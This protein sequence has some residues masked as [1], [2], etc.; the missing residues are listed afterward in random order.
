ML[1]L[2]FGILFTFFGL[3][4]YGQFYNGFEQDFG[5]NRIQNKDFDWNYLPFERYQVYY[6]LESTNIAEYA[7]Q[8]MQVVLTSIEKGLEYHLEEKIHV[9]VYKDIDDYRQ[10]NIGLSKDYQYGLSGVTKIAGSKIFIYNTGKKQDITAQ[11]KEGVARI[12]LNKMMFGSNWRD[13]IKNAGAMSLPEW[14]LEGL[15]SYIKNSHNPDFDVYLRDF[16]SSGKLKNFFHLNEENAITGGY[17]LWDYIAKTYGKKVIPNIIYMSRISRNIESGFLYVLGMPLKKVV[18]ECISFHLSSMNYQQQ[19][20]Q[21]FANN[22]IILGDNPNTYITDIKLSPYGNQIAYVEK[23][24]GLFRIQLLDIEENKSKTVFKGGYKNDWVK[25][26]DAPILTWVPSGDMIMFTLN[27][28][29][30]LQLY[31]YVIETKELAYKPLPKIDRVLSMSFSNDGKN[32]VMS[33]ISDGQTDLFEYSPR[34]NN[35]TQLTNDYYDELNPVYNQKN[36]ILFSSNR[37]SDTLSKVNHRPSRFYDLFSLTKGSNV[38]K[39]LTRTDDLDEMM[40]FQLDSIHYSY[41]A[42][43]DKIYNRYILRFDS[44][45]SHVDTAIHYKKVIH[46]LKTTDYP[47]SII[48]SQFNSKTGKLMEMFYLNQ[49]YYVRILP[50]S[51]S[52]VTLAESSDDTDEE[53]KKRMLNMVRSQ[54]ENIAYTIIPKRLPDSQS[55]DYIDTDNYVFTG[56][57]KM[58]K[59][60]PIELEVQT[61]VPKSQEPKKPEVLT[62]E[63]AKPKTELFKPISMPTP[64][65]YF[66]SISSSTFSSNIDLNFSNHIY[67]R[68]RGTS[69]YLNPGFGMS[70]GFE[71]KDL[72]E[73]YVFQGGVRYSFN[74]NFRDFYFN[75]SDRSSKIVKEYLIE[76]QVLEN[77]ISLTLNNK[78]ITNFASIT[79]RLPFSQ[80]WSIAGTIHFRTDKSVV[81]ATNRPSLD[82]PNYTTAYG[83]LKGELVYDNSSVK[84]FNIFSG[85]KGKLF[86]E[87]YNEV[88]NM[89]DGQQNINPKALPN[90]FITGLDY[91]KYITI[92]KNI[93]WAN[94]LAMSTSLGEQKVLYFMGG[95]DN[96]FMAIDQNLLNPNV[97]PQQNYLFQSRATNMRGQRVYSR[98]GN[99]FAIINSELRIPLFASLSDKTIK[100]DFIRHFQV[101]P[102][103]DIGTAW[104]GLH[105]YSDDNAFNTTII[106]DGSITI[107]VK[108]Q[109]QPIMTSIGTG[110]R[111]RLW[112]Y[113]VKFDVGWGLQDGGRNL[114][115]AHFSIGYD[116]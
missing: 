39:R 57:K 10:S 37:I 83:G 40:P 49:R 72:M 68:F 100:S 88:F 96:M 56:E 74:L 20:I 51:A 9:V 62:K 29:G 112:G 42:T 55:N 91:R 31:T 6:Y 33:A 1:R 111:S 92:Y 15:I 109:R 43:D 13:M 35:L 60:T 59:P 97:I 22:T 41:I 113:F 75:F 30:E 84:G 47:R 19:F 103:L 53:F 73:D 86:V 89:S 48:A 12:I 63:T 71:L 79:Y 93:I 116:F 34:S 78:T 27:K 102:F 108:N 95:V 23:Q 36:E 8:E 69:G 4:L 66:K 99:S 44:V 98:N 58:S 115:V 54:S 87:S 25:E 2:F 101:V 32:V 46:T 76:R 7:A 16:V 70:L 110:I 94:R 17:L 107:M 18:K 82:V 14:Y 77:S 85:T 106:K 90:T 114:P 50:F 61:E 3:S 38:L 28:K 26:Q 80:S 64:Q 81:S 67:Q 11:L 104:T 45:V 21:S 105:P 52:G 5:K 65:S 24:N